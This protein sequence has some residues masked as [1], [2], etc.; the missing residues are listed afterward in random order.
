MKHLKHFTLLAVFVLVAAITANSAHAQPLLAW[1]IHPARYSFATDVDPNGQ[2][3]VGLVNTQ[4]S[5]GKDPL[6][7]VYWDYTGR[8]P[9]GL[10]TSTAWDMGALARHTDISAGG[11]VIT[12]STPH[13]N[14]FYQG[15]AVYWRKG[16]G[17]QR[18]PF[19]HP[20]YSST[21]VGVSWDGNVIVGSVQ[22][23]QDDH[24]V[25]AYR[26]DRRYN[27]WRTISFGRKGSELVLAD[28]I[29]ANAGGG[30]YAAGVLDRVNLSLTIG[31]S[32]DFR[33]RFG[34]F[35][36]VY[37]IQNVTLVRNDTLVGIHLDFSDG[38]VTEFY[39][40]M[41]G[42]PIPTIPNG[43]SPDGSVVV[44]RAISL[45]ELPY[46]RR[47]ARDTFAFKWS[48]SSGVV[49]LPDHPRRDGREYDR[50]SAHACT[51]Y[52][53][54]VVGGA[55]RHRFTGG[56]EGGSEESRAILW[57]S[58]GVY[59]LN[60]LYASLLT[61]GSVLQYAYD[62][63]PDGRYIVGYGYHKPS[64]SRRAFYLRRW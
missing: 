3:M 10:T 33:V 22:L 36:F 48:P 39:A 57:T 53:D 7:Y 38:R 34:P 29:A 30:W 46:T 32:R 8:Y 19:P 1:D 2:A 43:I 60:Y 24:Y 31:G 35:D 15:D 4:R 50:H 37:S 44:G 55:M 41:A 14:G 51:W 52:G 54:E 23:L 6:D 21:A 27:T 62:I 26:W 58:G 59:D 13:S 5:S 28:I 20:A 16:V 49:L 11:Y 9:I 63:S 61:D 56:N 45:Y 12:T 64:N 17:L 25:R 40:V 47:R 42:Q 18:V